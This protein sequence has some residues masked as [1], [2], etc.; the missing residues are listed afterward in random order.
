MTSSAHISLIPT[1]GVTPISVPPSPWR[2]LLLLSSGQLTVWGV[3]YYTFAVVQVPMAREL[4]WSPQLL[5]GAFSC[6]LLVLALAGPALGR[7]YDRH[8]AR[9]SLL[10][11]TVLGVLLMLAWSQVDHPLVFTLIMAGVGLCV[12]ASGYEPAFWLIATWFA[13]RRARALTVL[14]L[15]GAMASPLYL[16][17]T[18][19]LC[20][21]LGWRPALMVLAGVLAVVAIPCYL[22]LPKA[23]AARVSPDPRLSRAAVA[24]ARGDRRFHWLQLGFVATSLTAIAIPVHLIPYLVAQGES[25]VFAASATGAIA[26]VGIA[27]RL[28][29]GALGDGRWLMPLTAGFFA[30]MSVAVLLLLTL[31]TR[32]GTLCFVAAFG[33]GYGALWPTRAAIVARIWSG[34][35]LGA[36]AGA[37]ALAPNL[38]K[39]AAPLLAAAIA[40]VIGFDGAFAVLGGLPLIAGIAILI[41]DRDDRR[42]AAIVPD[43]EAGIEPMPAPATS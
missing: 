16:P 25:S 5:A 41:A 28:V 24:E 12:A 37:F 10:A 34:P 36:I 20:A 22:L 29:F 33:L 14:T 3:L 26:F 32:I 21:T 40:V 17:L 27:G 43:V 9:G 31:P 38:A 15:F 39:A 7:W 35:N 4:G 23:Q 42:R 30:L 2:P 18:E 8:G 19:R 6:A 13:S 1:V 11:G